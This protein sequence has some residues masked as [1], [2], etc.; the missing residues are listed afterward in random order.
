MERLKVTQLLPHSGEFDRAA[1]DVRH[2]KGRAAA[3]VTVK[4]RED[5][6]GD[7]DFLEKRLGDVYRVLSCHRVA[8]QQCLGRLDGPGDVAELGHQLAIHVHPPCRVYDEIGVAVVG[9]DLQS[10]GGNCD[11]VVGTDLGMNGHTGLSSEQLQLAD[12]RWTA[13]IGGGEQWP[14]ALFLEAQGKLGRGGRFTR[15]LKTCD[16]DDARRPVRGYESLGLA[17][18][19][20]D[21]G[22]VDELND[23]LCG[24]KAL[25]DLGPLRALAH[26]LNE[27]LHHA[28]RHIGLEQCKAYLAQ[29]VVDLFL[30]EATARAE[31]GKDAVESVG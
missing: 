6:A 26:V 20:I 9:G 27:C 18:E 29:H 1:G 22:G 5:D 23:L 2:R 13:K 7:I 14:A 24:C 28:Q 10:L 31:P 25:V 30:V 4:L 8:D 12:G 16:Q 3:R 17:S 19:H 15:S 21:K 11:R